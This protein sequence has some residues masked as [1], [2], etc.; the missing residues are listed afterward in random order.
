MS[1][2]TKKILEEI[3]DYNKKVIGKYGND[4]NNAIHEMIT[5]KFEGHSIWNPFKDETG[6]FEIDPEKKYGKDKLNEFISM[7]KNN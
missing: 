1:N 5:F 3:V 2:I 7:Y 6:R 4:K